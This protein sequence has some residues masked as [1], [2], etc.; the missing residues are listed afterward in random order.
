[1]A[2][3][4]SIDVTSPK[5]A[6]VD[7]GS[8]PMIVG[9]TSM[10]TD[11]MVR[12]KVPEV[13]EKKTEAQKSEEIKEPEI[14]EKSE[15]VPP[16][17]KQKTLQPISDETVKEDA[18]TSKK[19][20]IDDSGLVE[21]KSVNSA[22]DKKSDVTTAVKEPSEAKEEIKIDPV[23]ANMER[24]ENIRK[25]I[26]SKKYNVSIKQA[27]PKGK[28]TVYALII[29]ALL[30]LAG[31]F[32]AIDTGKLNVGIALP[33]SIFGENNEAEQIQAATQLEV[34]ETVLPP[35]VES[36]K[37]EISSIDSSD[38]VR[39][40][41]EGYSLQL[42]DGWILQQKE[43][44][45]G[46]LFAL[47]VVKFKQGTPAV[48]D[49]YSAENSSEGQFMVLIDNNEIV[50]DSSTCSSATSETVVQ[51]YKLVTVDKETIFVQLEEGTKPEA[52]RGLGELASGEKSYSYCVATKT[53]EI[54]AR[55]T[56]NDS[57]DDEHT[58]FEESLKT[59][60]FTQ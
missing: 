52:E 8:K 48:V 14:T 49:D 23:A 45:S 44:N 26:D 35:V 1:M 2:D 10:A 19:D 24:E 33:F 22:D 11:P 7:I 50:A 57:A 30:A 15:L 5:D 16:S 18:V 27:H 51:S 4:K 39:F 20:V 46:S 59:L 43:G 12:E 17:A 54:R 21:T 25:I 13:A 36:T 40:T 37:N 9:H 34:V 32:V 3:K 58:Y 53:R 55:Y 42:P 60:T 29:F 47:G 6:K 38:W 41:G 56:L 31:L 28:G